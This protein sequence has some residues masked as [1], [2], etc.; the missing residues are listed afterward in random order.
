V[1]VIVGVNRGK[2]MRGGCRD[3]NKGVQ[4]GKKRKG[5]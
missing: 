1:A 3:K 2:E 4:R 5:E